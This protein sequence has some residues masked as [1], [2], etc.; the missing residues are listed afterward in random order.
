MGPSS[1]KQYDPLAELE[2]L[3]PSKQQQQ[4]KSQIQ[5]EAKKTP[6]KGQ[7]KGN[8]S[9]GWSLGGFFSKLAPKPKNQMILPDDSN[10]S[11]SSH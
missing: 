11:V 5:Q 8:T 6:E 2:A 9:G 7:N 4:A 10:P 3:D 1:N